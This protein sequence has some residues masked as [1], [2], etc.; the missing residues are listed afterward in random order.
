MK[1]LLAGFALAS[2][3]VFSQASPALGKATNVTISP[4]SHAASM[5]YPTTWNISWNAPAGSW[6]TWEFAYGDGSY[7]IGVTQGNYSLAKRHTFTS[8]G[9][10]WQTLWVWDHGDPYPPA[11][12]TA[13]S[14]VQVGGAGCH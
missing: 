4:Y 12:A 6:Q 3:L 5:G 2:M 7:D 13:Y 9:L 11:P 8:C 1:R 10:F 14:Y